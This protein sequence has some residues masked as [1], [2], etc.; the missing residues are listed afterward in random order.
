MN[1]RLYIFSAVLALFLSCTKELEKNVEAPAGEYDPLIH[2]GV[3]TY[4][5]PNNPST[6]TAYSGE[7]VGNPQ[8][9]RINWRPGVDK[10][11]VISDKGV[12]AAGDNE[13]D[14]VVVANDRTNRTGIRESEAEASPLTSGQELYWETGQED[15]FFFAVYPSPDATTGLTFATADSGQKATI[16]GGVPKDQTYIAKE[17]QSVEDLSDPDPKNHVH[18]SWEFLPDM[19]DA[20]MYASAQVAG[21]DVGIKKV[22]LRFKPLFNA[23]KFTLFAGDDKAK[24]FKVK[25]VTLSSADGTAGTDL[26]GQFTT[27]VDVGDDG[28]TGGFIEPTTDPSPRYRSVSVEVAES[29][30]EAFN[31]DTLKFTL[32]ALPLSQ[33]WLTLSVTF[34]DEND[35]LNPVERTRTLKLKN[36]QTDVWYTLAASRK[37]YVF[38]GIPDIEYVFEVTQKVEQFKPL[39]NTI[40]DFYSVSSYR[41]I[42]NRSTG[43]D[44]Y[45]PVP[46]EAVSYNIGGGWQS[47]GVDGSSMPDFTELQQYK[48]PGKA[49][50]DTDPIDVETAAVRFDAEMKE[51]YDLEKEDVWIN[52]GNSTPETAIDLSNY[53]FMTQKPYDGRSMMGNPSPS[54]PYE[55]AN[56]YVVSGPGWYKLPLVF[57]NGYQQGNVNTK[58][59]MPEA[60]NQYLLYQFIAGSWCWINRPWITRNYS[61]QG[62]GI[63]ANEPH[64]VWEDV[65][66]MV[67]DLNTSYEAHYL[68]FKVDNLA[69]RAGGNAVISVN[70]WGQTIWS[71][72]IWAV[73]PS[74]LTSQ[75][76]YY[77][78]DPMYASVDGAPANTTPPT[79]LASNEMLD[80]NLGYVSGKPDRYCMVRFRQ[81]ITGSER[82]IQ[83]VQLGD[84][85]TATAVHYQ[86]G[87]KDPMWSMS[88]DRS[89]NYSRTIYF[90]DGSTKSSEQLEVDHY[91]DRWGDTMYYDQY[92]NNLSFSVEN[93][94]IFLD[95][96]RSGAFAW[97]GERYDN[98]WDYNIIKRVGGATEHRDGHYVGKTVYDPCPPGFKV[99]N[100]YAFTGFNLKGMDATV[101]ENTKNEKGEKD[102]TVVIN[103][104]R[105]SFYIGDYFDPDTPFGSQGMYLYC[106]P[107]DKDNGVM[108]FPA[109]G[110]RVGFGSEAGQL[111]KVYS[112][113]L[114]WTSAPFN[115]NSTMHGRTF[116]MRRSVDDGS[117]TMN[118]PQCIPVYSVEA[119]PDTDWHS[120]FLRAHGLQVRPVRDRYDES[121]NIPFE[122]VENYIWV[123][124]GRYVTA[125]AI[126]L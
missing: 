59:Y 23:Y 34:L 30:R 112:E 33:S 53:N 123:P 90:E 2:F 43:K 66:D 5:G 63:D 65:E 108:F 113:G 20:Y 37:L 60:S 125:S 122:I 38:A 105:S 25:K 117:T 39:G 46:W 52:L 80:L 115:D 103:G 12:T 36:T 47:A 118:Y 42:F 82:D 51:L 13:A 99:P 88:G 24:K 73:P 81:D 22:P 21:K 45:Q 28:L 16:S 31:L 26:A 27:T 49:P 85:T 1:K 17:Q 101:D 55:T 64:L 68:Y 4:M 62:M 74:R 124:S 86:W 41:K 11:R 89:A 50:D 76:V 9:E 109:L 111:K 95:I 121:Y 71:W 6:K 75:E 8:Y 92:D 106:D 72:H 14:Y 79:K 97:S 15:H 114:Y 96:P 78:L 102:P 126:Y 3:E 93:P 104:I 58:A 119:A 91:S 69:N 116:T 48:G 54:S 7:L 35:P 56:C 83:L 120:G 40:D 67:T 32:L 98:L 94:M 100:E 84:P 57:G 87:R 77:W 61:E 18:N 29:D 70:A 10:I 19:T 107:R 44:E 110:R